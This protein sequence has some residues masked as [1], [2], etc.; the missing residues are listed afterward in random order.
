[1]TGSAFSLSSLYPA[2][3]FNLL[4]GETMLGG[5][6]GATRHHFCPSCMAWLYTQPEGMDAFVNVRSSMLDDPSGH[7]PFIETFRREGLSW[8]LSGAE[9]SFDTTPADE[10]FGELMGAYAQWDE[11]VQQ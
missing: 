3:A 8:V 1:M 7:R 5:L 6:K 2:S 11:R 9:K 4:Q 10:E